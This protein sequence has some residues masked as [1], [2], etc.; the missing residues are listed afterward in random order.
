MPVNGRPDL[1]TLLDRL[2][3][4]APRPQR[5]LWLMELL[6]WVRGPG[7]GT[8]AAVARV[9]LLLDAAQARPQWLPRW[10]A[11]W[12]RFSAEVDF[13]PLLAD[14]G[15]APRTAFFSE[16]GNRLRRKLLPATPDTTDLG[17]LFG[18]L[19]P[20]AGDAAWLR[21]LDDAT[22]ARADALLFTPP[23]SQD[24]APP[25]ITSWQAELL[26]ALMYS[27]SQVNATGFASEIRVRMSDVAR[28]A[29]TFHALPGAFGRFREAVADTGL[30][31]DRTA[32]AAATLRER[33]E[34]CRNAAYT[35]YAHLDEHGVSVG[36]V[37]RLRQLRERVL[38]TRELLDCLLAAQPAPAAV[39]LLAR[40]AQVNQ[41]S[42][43]LRELVAASSQ[44]T[45]AKVAE[46]SAESGEHYI[47]RDAAGYRDMLARAAGG[48]VVLAFT[49]WM[50]FSL[51][52]LGLSAF[53]GG[54]AAGLNY[55]VS[56]LVVMLMH[57]TVAT[58]QP[59]VTAPAMAAR[60]KDMSDAGVVPGFVD[61]VAH[62]LRSQVAAIA[63]NLG[64]VIPGVLLIC[65][66]LYAA[67][68]APMLDEAH[69]RHVLHEQSLLGPA[70]L[71][72][73][74]T[75][76]LLFASSVIAG[77]V[78]N[79][80]VLQRLDSAVAWNPDITRVLGA[81]RAQAWSRWLRDNISGVAANVSLGLMLGL[82]PAFAGFFGLGL[83]V[84]H[85][86]L[87]TGQVTAAVATLGPAAL[88]SADFWWAVA[89]LAVIG[90]LNLAVSF[91]LAFR[92]ALAARNVAGVDRARIR[93]ALRE[94]VRTDA[95]SFLLPPRPE[96]PHG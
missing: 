33:L 6:A 47:T 17:E 75:G 94:R 48:G 95:R 39:R 91:Y 71:F 61:E 27:V 55:S 66:G 57:W 3:P 82:V 40:L 65:G 32:E 36:I 8:P 16:F 18:L 76:V 44:M 87:S 22:L 19:F 42:R 64:L 31:S 63:G 60:L 96:A 85:I 92:L 1:G 21:A 78:E 34:Q 49:T 28:Q 50:K 56:F 62:L 58:K 12:A 38:R 29:R 30:S 86:T 74:F 4:Q 80:F 69:A 43:S 77:W 23:G 73:A 79:W 93:D 54:L 13:A 9:G 83:E 11:W 67:G 45:A 7:D 26:D 10:H 5:H 89:G 52:A 59:A 90:P 46:R 2:D 25:A 81:Q 70:A 15:F 72:A 68:L 84:R 53:W 20:S 37:F 35:V 41:D 14:F 88:A 51:M 24:N